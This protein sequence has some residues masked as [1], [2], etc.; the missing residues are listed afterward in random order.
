MVNVLTEQVLSNSINVLTEQVYIYLVIQ[1][2][3][4]C[5]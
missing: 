5:G 4:G 1:I 3:G 2:G